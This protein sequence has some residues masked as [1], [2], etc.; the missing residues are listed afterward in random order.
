MKSLCL[1]V[2][3]GLLVG[4]LTACAQ[5]VS[6]EVIRSEKPRATSA[7]V[8]QSE[9][10]TLVDG[11]SAFLLSLLD[12]LILDYQTWEKQRQLPSGLFWQ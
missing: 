5:P 2:L 4:M 12:P 9:L 8:N 1:W 10:A 11:N 3:I 7:Q 6:S